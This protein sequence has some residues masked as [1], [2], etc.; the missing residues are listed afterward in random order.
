MTVT[1][2]HLPAGFTAESDLRGGW[3]LF[4]NGVRA[5]VV[6]PEVKAK[7]EG[8]WYAR[9]PGAAAKRCDEGLDEAVQH[10]TQRTESR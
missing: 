5:G 3:V 4:N 1:D 8:A 9:L 2:L 7:P 6:F 10:I